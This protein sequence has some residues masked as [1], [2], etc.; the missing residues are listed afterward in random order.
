MF[1]SC[2]YGLLFSNWGDAVASVEIEEGSSE[3]FYSN[4]SYTVGVKFFILIISVL[5]LVV[6]VMLKCCCPNR[7]I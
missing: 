4:E 5:L 3:T 1:A 7:M 2:Y 6:S